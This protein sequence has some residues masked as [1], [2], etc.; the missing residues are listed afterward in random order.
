MKKHTI[1]LVIGTR[2]E[3]IK[4]AP[5]VLAL[6]A[7]PAFKPVVI[8]TGQHAQIVADMA[9]LFGIDLDIT[10][11]VMRP[12]DTLAALNARILAGAEPVLSA[13]KPDLIV[14]QGDTTSVMAMTLAAFYQHIPV[15]H[16]EAGLR[17][18]N[19][20][21]P[22]PEEANRKLV[23]C[24]ASLHF[25]PTQ[26]SADA[27][28]AEGVKREQI[29]ITGNTVVDALDMMRERA[30]ATPLVQDWRARVQGRR[31]ILATIHRRESWGD[32]LANACAALADIVAETPD[33]ELILPVH[34]GVAVRDTV[35]GLLGGKDRI[36]LIDPLDYLSFIGLAALA[37][38]IITD[39]GGL[40][41]EG[42]ALGKP[43]IVLRNETERPE[44]VEAGAAFLVGTD[45]ARI[46]SKARELLS[47]AAHAASLV[48]NPFG[49]GYAAA[50]IRR[51]ITHWFA[52]GSCALPHED[53]FVPGRSATIA[54]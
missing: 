45:R 6:K 51:S 16:V 39:S 15:A 28:M 42:A 35:R 3:L 9:P 34:P 48:S 36:H 22:F 14:V 38:L 54:A 30:A 4:M 29:A 33:V 47:G 37:S 19:L 11:D 46:V 44:A 13:L 20:A 53:E 24:L 12:G 41:E 40:Q 23:G 18:G 21:L 2:P 49:D 32:G 8:F 52:T 31:L 5:V 10:M 17:T 27:L 1:G 7:D 25:A 50:R 43:V 26:R